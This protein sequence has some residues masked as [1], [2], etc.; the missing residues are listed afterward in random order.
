VEPVA[1]VYPPPTIYAPQS[2]ALD[3]SAEFSQMIPLG[4]QHRAHVAQP[5]SSS[6]P[7]PVYV[8]PQQY[9]AAPPALAVGP[10]AAVGFVPGQVMFEQQFGSLQIRPMP[11]PPVHISPAEDTGPPSPQFGEVPVSSKALRFP[12]R[13]GKGRL[14][15]KCMVKANHFFADLPDKDL[16]QY[17]VSFLGPLQVI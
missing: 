11:P 1:Q 6:Q 12:L 16:H 10:A 2:A 15:Q 7:P 9:A 14:G 8:V 4:M 13:P 3:Q 17:D 5:A